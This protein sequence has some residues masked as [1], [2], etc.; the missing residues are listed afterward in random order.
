MSLVPIKLPPGMYRNGTPYQAWGRW[1]DGN[2]VRWYQGTLRPIGG[3]QAM[4]QSSAPAGNFTVSGV[5]RTA[6]GWRV[7]NT[8]WLAVGTNTKC[9]AFSLGTNTDITP[10]GFTAGGADSVFTTGPYG[11]GLYGAGSYGTGDPTQGTVTDAATWQLDTFGSYLVACCTSDGKLYYWDLNL[12]NDLLTMSGAPTGCIGVVVTPERFV[13]ALGAGGDNRTVQWADQESL[14]S[15]SPSATNQAGDFILTTEGRIRCGRRSRNETLIWTDV[16]LHAMRYIGGTLVYQF[17]R[18]GANCGIVAPN[19]VAMLDGMAAWMGARS[20][21]VYDGFVKP[22]ASEVSDYVFSDFNTAQRAKVVA[23][24]NAQFG[25]VTWYYPSGS[26]S[27]NDRYVTWNYRDNIWWTGTLARTAGFDSGAFDT[28]ILFSPAG[29]GYQHESGWSH[30]GAVPFAETGPIEMGNGDNVTMIRQYLP[31]EK[32]LGDVSIQIKSR[33][34]P[35][36]TETTSA[37]ISAGNPALL[38]V[39]GRQ[40]R[41]RIQEVNA[42]DWRF[43][44]ARFDVV[45]GGLR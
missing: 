11:A 2:L 1:Y 23:V 3:W 7:G 9:Y 16:D 33:F 42:G 26:S 4:Q 6:I 41:I 25:E 18:L 21:F 29:I 35:T 28:P 30:S 12:S 19:A 34:Y 24:P 40:H 39:T 14:T 37:T 44:V 15:W 8:A 38:R 27:E 17:E 43:G 32:T 20:F 45:A 10:A 36:S 31:D 22:L 5:P 13:V